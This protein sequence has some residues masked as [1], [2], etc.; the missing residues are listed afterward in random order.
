MGRSS[1][2][3]I[4]NQLAGYNPPD[5]LLN[6]GDYLQFVPELLAKAARALIWPGIIIQLI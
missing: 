5:M 6:F 2:L 3:K 4:R 1:K